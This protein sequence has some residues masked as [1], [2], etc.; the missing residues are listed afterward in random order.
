MLSRPGFPIRRR[1]ALLG[2]TCAIALGDSALALAPSVGP[3]QQRLVVVILRGALDGMA[4]LVP[5]GDA[6]LG[7]LRG[8]LLLPGCGQPG[9]LLDL[10]GF[11]GL[12]PALAGLHGLYHAGEFLPVHA[13]IGPSHS[14]SHFDAQD[15]L[16]SGT[17]HRLNSG[18]LNRAVSLL[19]GPDRPAGEAMAIGPGVPLLLRGPAPASNWSPEA[20]QAPQPDLYAR[21]AELSRPDPVLG[22]AIAEG[23]RAQGVTQAVLGP[24]SRQ[25]GRTSFATLAGAAGE[26]LAA[27][28][29]PRI[30]AL[31]IGGWDTHAAQKQRLVQPLTQL[32]AGLVALRSGLGDAWKQTA[33][34]VMTEFGRTARSNGTGGTDHGTAT[35]AFLLGGAVRGGRV[36]G[37]WPGLSDRQLF[38]NRDLSP[39]TDLR[40]L[41][42]GLLH[43]HLGLDASALSTVFPD[44]RDVGA[45]RGLLV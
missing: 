8:S 10:G 30:A 12:H 4:A 43:D 32:D 28:A 33:V 20:L 40:A 37:T 42:K 41:A 26:L 45:Q 7:A 6:R 29:G 5:Y 31:E 22:P 9:G 38:E 27:P 3:A 17:D 36:G 21:I 24:T 16:E 39:T 15:D 18:W 25:A 34:L 35:V 19:H 11:Y 2:L 44:S 13:V 1:Q 14:R 23:L